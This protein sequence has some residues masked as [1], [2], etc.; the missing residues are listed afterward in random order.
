MSAGRGKVKATE[1]LKDR[2]TETGREGVE[3]YQGY[4]KFLSTLKVF[5][6]QQAPTEFLQFQE[7]TGTCP[8]DHRR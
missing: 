1:K 7:P 6:K 5:V 3:E 2:E 4:G 8:Q